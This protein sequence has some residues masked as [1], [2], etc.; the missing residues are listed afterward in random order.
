MIVRQA[1][2]QILLALSRQAAVALL[3]PRQVGKTTLAL[4]IAEQQKALY[5]DLEDPLERDKLANPGPFLAGLED[6]LV[7][8]DEIHR[9]PGLFPVLRGLID[10]GRRKGKRFG[11]FLLLGSASPELLRQSGETLAGRISF[12]DL[13]PFSILE[14]PIEEMETLWLRGGFP[15]SFLAANNPHSLAWRKDMI[16]TYL[17]R[18]IPL[19]GPRLPGETLRRFWTMIAHTQ[20]SLLNSAK[21]AGALEVSNPT[22]NRYTDLLVD[23][24]LLRRLQPYHINVKKRLVKK[25]KIYIR[26]SGLLHALL[27]L[28]NA[29]AVLGHP[30]AGG[31]WEGFV[32][33]NLIQAAPVGTV[34]GFYR[35]SAG[36]EMDLVMELPG[37]KRWVFEI[38]RSKTG[39]TSRGFF[40]ACQDLRPDRNFLIHSG[41][42]RFP[43]SNQTEVMGLGEMAGLLQTL[44]S[45]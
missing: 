31:S 14:V 6:R 32:I 3:G 19:F 33:E 29:S 23:L 34:P 41:R 24:L 28:E 12:L 20:G 30:V 27:H 7:I 45:L 2:N 42:E 22:I 5:F 4:E 8:L 25:P 1:K 35:T 15:D 39:K 40:E 9:L 44:D 26:D 21:L 17:E 37:G 11:R 36:A 18:D 43:L 16:R 10:Q 13:N 38:K